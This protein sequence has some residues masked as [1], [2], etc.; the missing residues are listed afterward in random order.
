MKTRI[1][2]KSETGW[3]TIDAD[4]FTVPQHPEYSF[5]VHRVLNTANP[6]LMGKTWGVTNVDTGMSITNGYAKTKKEAITDALA[7]LEKCPPKKMQE[8]IVYNQKKFGMP[9]ISTGA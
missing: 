6:N 1:A 9:Q 7:R 3:L 8:A 5:A 2:I 4:T